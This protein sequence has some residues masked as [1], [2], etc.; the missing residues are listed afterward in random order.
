MST[1][2]VTPSTTANSGIDTLVKQ[3]MNNADTNK[4]GQL[5][6]AEFGAFL[7]NLIERISPGSLSSKSSTT[8][9]VSPKFA[10]DDPTPT[11]TPPPATPAAPPAVAPTATRPVDYWPMSGFDAAKLNDMSHKSAKYVFGRTVQ[12]LG[13]NAKDA[14]GHLDKV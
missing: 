10:V 3:I 7:T 1:I 11:V 14:R 13:L 8:Q 4:D 2:S 6:S 12:D 9:I 5:S